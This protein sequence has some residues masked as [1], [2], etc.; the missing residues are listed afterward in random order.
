MGRPNSIPFRSTIDDHKILVD[1][2]GNIGTSILTS[3]V[4]DGRMTFRRSSQSCAP[5][6]IGEPRYTKS[7][8][9]AKYYACICCSPL[10]PARW[11]MDCRSNHKKWLAQPFSPSVA[12]SLS[13]VVFLDFPRL[14][15]LCHPIRTIIAL[16]TICVTLKSMFS[17]DFLVF[18][19][20][21]LWLIIL[22][23]YC[24]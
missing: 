8:E 3:Y 18:V 7:V 6:T 19:T 1:A 23:V 10:L 5:V 11:Y 15:Y 12:F 24:L 14:Q 16:R 17:I 21:T 9:S 4:W 22:H 2:S 20:S 13:L